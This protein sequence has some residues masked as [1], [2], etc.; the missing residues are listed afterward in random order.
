MIYLVRF[1][2]ELNAKELPGISGNKTFNKLIEII[3]SFSLFCMLLDM[4]LGIG[5]CTERLQFN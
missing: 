2:S 4:E 5:L 3:C 1:T